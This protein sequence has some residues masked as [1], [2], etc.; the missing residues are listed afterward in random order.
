MTKRLGLG[1]AMVI[2]LL[3]LGAPSAHAGF[4]SAIGNSDEGDQLCKDA[5]GNVVGI[6]SL[7]TDGQQVR[8]NLVFGSG[9]GVIG[10]EGNGQF[11][12]DCSIQDNFP[13]GEVEFIGN[14]ACAETATFL[15]QGI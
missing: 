6:G 8:A 2:G 13:D 4:C 10:I 14:P 3:G 11:N 7:F 15:M 5:D 1:I 9:F 12:F